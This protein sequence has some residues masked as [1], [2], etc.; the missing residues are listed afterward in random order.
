VEQ[1]VSSFWAK[2]STPIIIVSFQQ[3]KAISFSAA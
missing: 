2:K 3:L 1:V